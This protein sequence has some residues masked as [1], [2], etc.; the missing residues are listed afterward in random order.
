MDKLKAKLANGELFKV[1]NA[2]G[3]AA[4]WNNFDIIT[5]AENKPIGHVQCRNCST[6]LAYD[7]K[8]TG[9]SHLQRHVDRGCA[10][11]SASASQKQL[12][13]SNFFSKP[14]P[15]NVKSQVTEKCVDFCCE[16]IRPF[17]T[18]A[19]P[20]FTKLAQELINIGATHGRLSAEK[21][22]PDPTTISRRCL[23]M[24]ATQR[25][26]LVAEIK[27]VLCSVNV[28]MT[29]DM[30]TD[31]YR[32]VSYMAITCHFVTP[33]YQLKSNV[34]TTAMF[35]SEEAKTAVNIRTELQQQLVSVLGFEASVMNKVVWVTDQGSNIVAALR[36]YRRLDCQDHVYNSHATCPRHD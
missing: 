25:E 31:D 32:K 14:V 11:A 36:P 24:A 27:E 10:V 15:A 9:S 26:K 29:T 3:K 18:V 1:P 6:I 16:D 7:S 13:M 34:L 2:S 20:G 19:G 30:W 5:N 33:D 12:S 21:V 17:R 8:K 4:L 28:G 23:D 35:P 22:L